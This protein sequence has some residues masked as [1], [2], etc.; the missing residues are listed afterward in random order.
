MTMHILI[1]IHSIFHHYIISS[2]SVSLFLYYLP[3]AYY[4]IFF[5]LPGILCV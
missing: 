3:N 1:L 4:K 5:S 2:V